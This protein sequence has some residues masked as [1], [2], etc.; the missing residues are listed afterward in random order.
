M[1]RYAGGY[2]RRCV[3][4]APPLTAHAGTHLADG[5]IGRGM[6][7]DAVEVRGDARGDA[8]AAGAL[9]RGHEIEQ[10]REQGFDTT[11]LRGDI[12]LH[13]PGID[14]RDRC[15]NIVHGT[16]GTGCGDRHFAHPWLGR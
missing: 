4:G 3:C 8:P 7:G 15:R 6:A 12:A 11:G 2:L 5:G 9:I 10:G 13:L 16:F 14:G 1:Q